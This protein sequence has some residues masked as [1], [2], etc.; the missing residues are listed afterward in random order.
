MKSFSQSLVEVLVGSL[1]HV[2]T[3]LANHVDR[4][5][6]SAVGDDGHDGGVNDTQV[7]D[8]VDLEGRVDD[9]LLN[10]LGETG[11]AAR[12]EGSLASV[13]DDAAH[14]LVVVEGHVPGVLVDN[15]VLEALALGQEVVAEADTLAHGDDVELALEEVEVDVGV[16]QVVVAGQGDLTR[17]GDGSHQ[18]DDD[19]GVS[20]DL[21]DGVVP[22]EGTSED[23]DKVQLEVR[24]AIGAER[25]LTTVGLDGGAVDGVLGKVL[26]DT[27]EADHLEEARA[28]RAGEV[29]VVGGVGLDVGLVLAEDGV[30][31]AVLVLDLEDEGHSRVV[32]QV[33][34]NVAGVDNAL[35]VVLGQLASGTDTAEHEQLRASVDTLRQDD[36]AVGVEAELLA[37]GTD[38]GDTPAGAV[39]VV[40]EELLGV[41]LG[42]DG[43]VG[44]VLEEE[45]AAVSL[46]L[47]DG[48]GAVVQANH[49]TVVDVLSQGLAHGGPGLG[50]GITEGSHLR[51]ELGVGDI[52]GTASA[53]LG[54]LRVVE[55]LVVVVGDTLAQV[56]DKRVPSPL[57]TTILSPHVKGRLASGDPSEVIKRRAATEDL[58]T[59][60][61]LLD[62]LVVVTLDNGGLVGPVMLAATE[63]H[64][65]GGGHDLLQLLGVGNTGLDD[66]D[67][68]IG[69]LSETTGNGVTGSAATDDD[70]VEAVT[71]VD[72]RSGRH[73]DGVGGV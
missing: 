63:V 66:E 57:L 24:L 7:L 16:V 11:T 43:D 30:V 40:D 52:D 27:G 5:L 20:A 54:Q 26:V 46:A 44:L 50:E 17:L 4:V 62:T 32:N 37:V 9:T 2:G 15:E 3:L 14:L 56:G 35:N 12:V 71:R 22:L 25:I 61:G 41:H 45:E 28:N 49:L 39:G 8:T 53:N 55:A 31:H 21:G 6:D 38:N 69:V 23:G 64:G 19:G 51:E 60:V 1:D 29:L 13:E 65:V 36:F 70:E 59:G 73:D 34:T 47:V 72:G 48:V 67:A 33:L 42:E 18:V 10:V 68:D 58:A